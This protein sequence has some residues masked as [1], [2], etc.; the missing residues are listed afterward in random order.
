MAS[1]HPP[2]R[3]TAYTYSVSLVSQADTKLFKTTVTL[4][5]GDVTVSKDGGNFASV[6]NLPVEIQTSGVI[7]GTLTSTEMTADR[8]VVRFRDAAGAEWCDTLLVIDTVAN[9][10]DDLALAAGVNVMQWKGQTPL[11]L[12]NGT[13]PSLLRYILIADDDAMSGIFTLA[14]SYYYDSGVHFADT[15]ENKQI[16]TGAIG[17]ASANLDT[18]LADLPT[19]AELATALAAADDAVLAAVAGITA[20]SA[21]DIADAVW[22]EATAGHTAAGSTGLAL[23]AAGSAGD[24]WTTELPAGYTGAQAGALLTDLWAV[25]AGDAVADDA[26][27][28]TTVTY[29]NPDGD[30][31]VTHTLTATTRTKT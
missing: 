28:P 13:V 22:D 19:N 16:I 30:P 29:D 12:V 18:Q 4:A 25:M 3:A 6:T 21:A 17:L 24:P 31:Q 20:P 1:Q 23:T 7:V 14:Q 10:F 5:A 8:V 26:T 27:E 2:K 15:A 11:E 9:R